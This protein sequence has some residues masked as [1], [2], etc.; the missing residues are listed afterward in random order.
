MREE[1]LGWNPGARKGKRRD[2][3]STIILF[4]W[5][6][7]TKSRAEPRVFKPAAGELRLLI[8]GDP[9]TSVEIAVSGRMM[10]ECGR[11]AHSSALGDPVIL[12]K[13]RPYAGVPLRK[14]KMQTGH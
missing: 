11:R 1:R 5:P 12:I 14:P 13:E 4:R 3:K 7:G 8:P 9:A 10:Q 2:I 6:H